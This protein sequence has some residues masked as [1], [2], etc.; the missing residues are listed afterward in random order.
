[1]RRRDGTAPADED[2]A[3]AEED[4]APADEDTTSPAEDDLGPLYARL[5]SLRHLRP[6]PV[7]CFAF[8]EGSIALATVLALIGVVSWWAVV[9]LPITIAAMVL[10][11]DRVAGLASA[12]AADRHR[13]R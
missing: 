3:P 6:G 1:M 9:V 8:F 7:T 12:P 13:R 10:L 4:M 11:N 5:L 2:M